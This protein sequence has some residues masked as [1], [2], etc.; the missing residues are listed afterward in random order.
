MRLRTADWRTGRYRSTAPRRQEW[1]RRRLR[2][3]TRS[4]RR[5]G[6][7][8]EPFKVADLSLAA[9]G[10]NEIRLAEQEMPGLM[11][12]RQEY[13]EKSPLQGARIM[14][15]LHMTVQTAVLIETLHDL[16]ADGAGG[17][18]A[19]SSRP[20]D[21]AAAAVG[22]GAGRRR[23]GRRRTPR[24]IPVF[25]WKGESLADYWWCTNE[26][27]VWPDGGGPSLIVDDGGDATLLVH[28]GYEFEQLGEGAG[29]STRRRSRKSGGSSSTCCGTSRPATRGTGGAS[30]RRFAGSARRPPP[31]VHRLLRDDRGRHPAVPG[32]Q[33]ERLGDQEQVRQ[34]LRLPPL[35]ARR[36]R[37]GDR[38]HARAGRWRSC[39]ASAR[40]GRA[41]P[42]GP[43][44]ARVCRVVVTEIDPICALQAAMEGYE[45]NTLEA[46]I[47]RADIFIT[48]T[49]NRDIHLG[50]AHGAHEGQGH[51]G[52]TS[53]T[54]T[55]RSTW[56]A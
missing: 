11:A 28:K 46:M 29:G 24:G 43:A 23:G 55:T 49:G 7:D 45:V 22:G 17:C 25:A 6:A 1:D 52:P 40:W 30:A 2:P 27:L 5:F 19:T 53:G 12:L 26:A 38:R 36:S 39:A 48:A 3:R 41:A 15:S 33:R 10:R 56:P 14:G 44:G 21:H 35:A 37:A 20:Q 32:H 34:R 50:P 4:T 13:A 18:R 16:G 9:F 8:R 42:Q 31:G 54:S 47:E 51:R